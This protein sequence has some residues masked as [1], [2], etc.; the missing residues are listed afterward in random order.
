MNP[1]EQIISTHNRSYLCFLYCCFKCRQVYLTERSFIDLDIHPVP[2][3]FLIINSKMFHT[4]PHIRTL[5]PFDHLNRHLWYQIWIFTEILK[6]SSAKR[7]PHDIDTRRKYDIL[8]TS[9][10][11]LSKYRSW[12]SCQFPVPGCGDRTVTR[13]I[14]NSIIIMSGSAPV[15]IKEFEPHP[16]RAVRHHDWG[17][18]KSFY[19]PGAEQTRTMDHLYFLF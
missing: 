12:F 5:D 18:S 14:C 17:D 9:S 2:L 6:I 13:T 11:F 19:C 10:G 4:G 3:C 8:A 15:I 7:R 1:T 16:C